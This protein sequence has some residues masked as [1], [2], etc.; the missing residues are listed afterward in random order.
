MSEMP[1]CKR[2][3]A[4]LEPDVYIKQMILAYEMASLG[5]N[6][7]LLREFFVVDKRLEVAI[8]KEL[9][10]FRKGSTWMTSH[11]THRKHANIIYK[12][13]CNAVPENANFKRPLSAQELL[14]LSRTYLLEHNNEHAD[15][16]RIHYIFKYLSDGTFARKLCSTCGIDFIFH[17]ER[18][19]N[20]CP[21]C[22]KDSKL[23]K[24]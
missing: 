21:F 3:V 1:D 7:P 10:K 14:S 8:N 15:I 17:Y 4:S 23:F 13:Y 24:R 20:H 16:N 11:V 12:M 22:E 5:A 9:G 19:Y 6:A 2:R 18:N